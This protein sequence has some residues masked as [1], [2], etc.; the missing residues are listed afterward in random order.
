MNQTY[1]KYISY[2]FKLG[3][4]KSNAYVLIIIYVHILSFYE[5]VFFRRKNVSSLKTTLWPV[6]FLP[7]DDNYDENTEHF[8]YLS[9]CFGKFNFKQTCVIIQTYSTWYI[10]VI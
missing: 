7:D 10:S 1:G 6:V 4:I 2:H 9:K 5:C 3:R 8:S